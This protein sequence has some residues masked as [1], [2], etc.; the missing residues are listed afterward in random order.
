MS[1]VCDILAMLK[2]R[3][4]AV[5]SDE[6]DALLTAA[7]F[8]CVRR[9]DRPFYRHPSLPGERIFLEVDISGYVAMSAVGEA[10]GAV[11]VLVVCDDG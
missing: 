4:Q 8:K 7:G 1:D 5:E 2:Q 9:G 3:R 11:E 10:F 6:I